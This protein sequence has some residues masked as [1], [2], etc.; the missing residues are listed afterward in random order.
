MQGDQQWSHHC[1]L[2]HS[3]T[4]QTQQ[5]LSEEERWWA[6]SSWKIYIKIFLWQTQNYLSSLVM[7]VSWSCSTVIFAVYTFWRSRSTPSITCAVA[8]GQDEDEIIFSIRQIIF[9]LTWVYPDLVTPVHITWTIYFNIFINN[10]DKR[11]AEAVTSYVIN[12]IVL[13]GAGE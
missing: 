6:V 2:H 5:L 9:P 10:I 11:E 3:H 7:I 1:H 12:N 4:L 13:A 8:L